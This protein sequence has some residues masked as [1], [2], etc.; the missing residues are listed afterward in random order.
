M[1]HA[2]RTP[3]DNCPFRTDIKG[4]LRPDRVREIATALFQGQSFPCHK[5]TEEWEDDDGGEMLATE[6]SQ[7]CAGAEI[8][9][10]KQ[11][12][13]TQMSRIAERLGMKV[14]KPN[15]KAKVCGSVSEMLHVHG[16]D[17]DEDRESCSVCDEDCEAPAGYQVGGGA[18]PGEG[19]AEYCCDG[20][21]EPVCGACSKPIRGKRGKRIC[22]RCIEDGE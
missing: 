1:K 3:C 8:F 17:E 9:L 13:S 14:A 6:D 11:G 22:T 4:Y 5:T 16:G 20:C 19:S 15:M 18:V 21:G 10:A 12:M 2:M 7:Q